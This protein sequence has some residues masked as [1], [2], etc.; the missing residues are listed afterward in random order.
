MEVSTWPKTLGHDFGF[1]TQFSSYCMKR[2]PGMTLKRASVHL[3]LLSMCLGDLER[4]GLSILTIFLFSLLEPSVIKIKSW[5]E[6]GLRGFQGAWP[7][8]AGAFLQARPPPHFELWEGQSLL[9]D[10]FPEWY[11]RNGHQR[12]GCWHRLC[13]RKAERNVSGQLSSHAGSSHRAECL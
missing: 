2:F 12:W 9:Q 6:L 3:L 8:A 11:G 1:S 5:A 4:G 13:H 10:A 7:S